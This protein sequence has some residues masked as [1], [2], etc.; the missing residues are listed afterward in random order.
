MHEAM[1]TAPSS[2]SSPRMWEHGDVAIATVRGVND[3]KVV[4]A[5]NNVVGPIPK[6]WSF[7]RIDGQFDHPDDMVTNL[8]PAKVVPLESVVLTHEQALSVISKLAGSDDCLVEYLIEYMRKQI[9]AIPPPKPPK[10]TK[11]GSVIQT[12]EGLYWTLVTPERDKWA[13]G[14]LVGFRRYDQLNAIRVVPPEEL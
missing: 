1:T 5:S 12:R 7:V 11:R 10:P 9:A 8:V 13:N 14:S 3:V 2:M 6:W 4:R